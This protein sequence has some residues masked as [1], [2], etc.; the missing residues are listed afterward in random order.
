MGSFYFVD[1]ALFAL[2]FRSY[3]YYDLLYGVVGSFMYWPGM[4]VE[5]ASFYM[6]MLLRPTVI[7]KLGLYLAE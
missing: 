6:F 7:V 2:F 5:F 4:W 3:I 1:T